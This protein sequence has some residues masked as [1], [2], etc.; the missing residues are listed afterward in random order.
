M[1]DKLNEMWTALAAYQPKADANGHGAS[2]AFMCSERTEEAAILAISSANTAAWH[3]CIYDD[4]AYNAPSAA[5]SAGW[6]AYSYAA[7]ATDDVEYYAQR[8]IN[9]IKNAQGNL[10]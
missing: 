9:Q 5:E 7:S 4:A 1:D 3:V 10:A 6:A 8:S 2:W